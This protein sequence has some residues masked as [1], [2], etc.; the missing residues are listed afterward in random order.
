MSVCAICVSGA[1]RGQKSA[2]GAMGLDLQAIVSC[3]AALG[4]EPKPGFSAGAGR[5][6]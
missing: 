6:F 3:H 4:T 5:A 2:A 1:F